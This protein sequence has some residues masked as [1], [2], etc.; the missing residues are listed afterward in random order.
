MTLL[1]QS[2]VGSNTSNV[3]TSNAT[4][5]DQW[6]AVSSSGAGSSIK[7]DNTH[8]VH[9]HATAIQYHYPSGVSA[10]AY[11]AWKAS[12]PSA[13][14]TAY[15]R[16][17]G[18]M[19]ANPTVAGQRVT[20]MMTGAG[21]AA[22]AVQITTGGKVRIVNSAGTNI[23][24][25]TASLPL[26][27]QWRLE[28]DVTG[29]SGS[30]GHPVARFYSGSNLET[31]TPDETVDGGAGA[32]VG[33]LINEVR[34]GCSTAITQSGANWDVWLADMAFSDTAQPGVYVPP[35]SSSGAFLMFM[36]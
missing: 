22:F 2:G 24:T 13:T 33:G 29:I 14:A 4:S 8:V 35:A 5:G 36:S 25:S 23:A 11:T 3:T 12:I 28:V 32:A 16:L 21:A 26:N 19:T 7:Y 30:T 9:S 6:N 17:Y 18:Y 10:L 27:A 31:G 20:H 1:V 15:A 34:Y